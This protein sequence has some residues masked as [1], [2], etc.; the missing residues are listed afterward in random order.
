MQ[1]W[2]HTFSRRHVY[3]SAEDPIWLLSHFNFAIVYCNLSHL[4]TCNLLLAVDFWHLIV[5]V[6]PIPKKK[7]TP[8]TTRA[9]QHPMLLAWRMCIHPA[10]RSNLGI[11]SDIINMYCCE[12]ECA[13]T[14]LKRDW[15]RGHVS[16]QHRTEQLRH[17]CAGASEGMKAALGQTVTPRDLIR[18]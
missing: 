15:H 10:G 8:H 6:I 12:F 11:C 5:S 7:K 2:E 18:E 14:K 16:I 1:C 13:V 3:V 9:W 4:L 17:V